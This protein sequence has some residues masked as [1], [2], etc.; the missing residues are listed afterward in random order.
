MKKYIIVT[1]GVI[2]GI[3][4]GI[5]SASIARLMKECGLNVNVLKIDPY[6]NVDAGTMNPNQ[7][8]EVFVTDDGYEADLDL[9]HYERFLGTNMSRKNNM[10]AGQV[11]LN[12]IE[13][14][15]Q[16]KY[17]GSTVQIVPHLTGEIKARIKGM[18]GDL[19]VVEIGGT[20]GDIEGEVFLEAVRE[21]QLEEGKENFLFVHVTYVPYLKTT[22]EFK[23]KPTQQSVQQLRKI[24]INPDMIVVRSEFPID[25]SSLNKVALFG[26]V[27]KS[28]VINLPDTKNV[29][30]IPEIL[31]NLEV[32][33][34]VARKLNLDITDSKFKWSYPKVFKPYRI[35]LVGKYLGTDDAYKSIIESVFLTGVERPTVIDSQML[36]E[37]TDSEVASV[38]EEFDALIIPGGFGKRG[39]E[40][41]IKAI[42]FARE[43]KKPILGIC[44]GMQLMVV[45]FAR[46]VCNL[47]NA[48]ST[49]FDPGTPHPVID[50]MEEQKKILRLGGTMRLGAQRIEIVPDTLLWKIYGESDVSERHRHRY[51]VNFDSYSYIFKK[52]GEKGYKLV[53]SARSQ[54][55]EAVELEDHP[56]F[57]GIQFHPEYKSKVGAPHPI[58]KAFVDAIGGNE[59]AGLP[60]P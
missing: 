4:K 19:L 39:I 40:G 10:T 47:E 43:R 22:N 15:R 53:I 14:E 8:G 25:V 24:G 6:L 11:Y 18:E 54:F 2:S 41:K 5:F 55:V 20:V 46:N 56:F 51:E 57:L 27:P 9:G 49:E 7:H 48:N 37:S 45:E 29:Y 33:K 28:M 23:T 13:K 36:E 30:E 31:Y 3:G 35:A 34:K 16:G 44:L 26:G 38:L 17:L 42:K 12:V 58:F 50:L 59:N 1:G 60:R 21:L 52:P 32:H